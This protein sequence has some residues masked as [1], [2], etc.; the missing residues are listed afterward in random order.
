MHC[1]SCMKL[2]IYIENKQV[3]LIR[4]HPKL[5]LAKWTVFEKQQCIHTQSGKHGYA[6]NVLSTCTVSA[7]PLSSCNL[8]FDTITF[9]V[10]FV[11]GG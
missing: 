3:S 4:L 5:S 11:R 2:F 6:N 10:L 1:I 8:A 7:S 9:S